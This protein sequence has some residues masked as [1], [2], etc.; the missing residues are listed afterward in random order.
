M[1]ARWIKLGVVT[2]ASAALI[3][4]TMGPGGASVQARGN[5]KKYCEQSVQING[6]SSLEDLSAEEITQTRA[7]ELEKGF[8]R[9]VKLAP[10]KKLSNTA[11]T[12]SG[13]FGEVADGTQVTDFSTEDAKRFAEALGHW[14]T[15][16]IRN[17]LGEII[18]DI[19]LPDLDDLPDITLP[20][21]GR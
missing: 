10:T 16:F 5:K 1:H 20:D 14:S 17:C 4:G 2:V 8:K 11:K 21:I 18:P 9:L 12:L 19:T 15:Y 3:V 6:D 13:Y 7:A